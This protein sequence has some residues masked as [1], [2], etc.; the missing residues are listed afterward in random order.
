MGITGDRFEGKFEQ[1]TIEIVRT[2]LDK[3]VT[4]L[5]DG[6][7]VFTESVALPHQWDRQSEFHFEGDGKK[8]TVAVHSA[9]KKLLGFL[10]YDNAYTIEVDGRPLD[11]VK[12]K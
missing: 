1:H 12:T 4:L 3:K 5:V 6:H 8:H 10:P 2:N 7:E 9:F 11:L